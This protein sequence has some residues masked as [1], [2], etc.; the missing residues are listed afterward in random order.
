MP[1]KKKLEVVPLSPGDRLVSEIVAEMTAAGVQPDA[2]ET[3]L[4]ATACSIVNRLDALETIINREGEITMTASGITRAHPALSE[5]RQ[6]AVALPKVL[7]G[8]VIG[9]SMTGGQKNPVKQ[10]AANARWQLRDAQLQ[11]RAK[12]AGL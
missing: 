10:R 1:P 2:K 5:F 7:S 9:D 11:S 6:Y 8:I 4:L 12:L 3:A